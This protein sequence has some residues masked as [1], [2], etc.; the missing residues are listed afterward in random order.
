MFFSSYSNMATW[1][2]L[3]CSLGQPRVLNEEEIFVFS[4]ILAGNVTGVTPTT[5]SATTGSTVGE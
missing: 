4:L 3:V 5:A 1:Q 2:I